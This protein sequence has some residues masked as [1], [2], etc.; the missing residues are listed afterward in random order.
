MRN[1]EVTEING[2]NASGEGIERI[3]KTAEDIS[4]QVILPSGASEEDYVTVMCDA[5]GALLNRTGDYCRTENR[6][7]STVYIFLCGRADYEKLAD[8]YESVDRKNGAPAWIQSLRECARYSAEAH[9]E[10]KYLSVVQAG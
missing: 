7:I 8:E 10:S 4:A 5:S 9:F 1:T 3:V 2:T 6:D